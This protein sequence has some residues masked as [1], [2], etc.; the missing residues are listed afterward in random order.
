MLSNFSKNINALFTIQLFL[1][2]LFSCN[3]KTDSK[4]SVS[5]AEDDFFEKCRKTVLNEN[6]PKHKYTFKV[7]GKTIDE[8]NLEYL[9]DIKTKDIGI[10]KILNS[11]QYFGL[12]KDSKRANSSIV[13]YDN[14]NEYLGRYNVGNIKALPTKIKNSEL[15]FLYSD[16]ECNE[17]TS[18]DFMIAFPSK[19]L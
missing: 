10:L 13:L 5:G 17:A 2:T 6:N 1:I 4:E 19:F 18:I 11:T 12:Y 16:E 15:V 3:Y 7:A 9:G 14:R 8:L